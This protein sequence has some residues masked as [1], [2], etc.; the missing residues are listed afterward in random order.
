MNS[1]HSLVVLAGTR[2]PFCRAGTDLATFDAAAL[3]RMAVT[4]LLAKTGFDPA[5][6][7]ET[8]FGNVANPSF[9]EYPSAIRTL[10]DSGSCS[11]MYKFGIARPTCN[12]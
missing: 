10:F 8:I 9:R 4:S 11:A 5:A 6:V 12:C 3:G 7:D 1:R 2:T